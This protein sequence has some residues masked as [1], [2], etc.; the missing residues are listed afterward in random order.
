MLAAGVTFERDYKDEITVGEDPTLSTTN[1]NTSSAVQCLVLH[2]ASDG[3][4]T[5]ATEHDPHGVERFRTS[6][7]PVI[8]FHGDKDTTIPI[9]RAYAVQ[10]AY[11]TNGVP[12]RLHVLSGCGHAS[13]CYDGH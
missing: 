2:W 3:G 8:A 12:Y 6:N 10:T 4:V 1:L 13:W 5:L 9:E 11:K 7:P